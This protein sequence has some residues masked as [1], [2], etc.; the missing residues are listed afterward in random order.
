MGYFYHN[1][2]IYYNIRSFCTDYDLVY[3]SVRYFAR[4]FGT[5]DLFM[6]HLHEN[7]EVIDVLIQRYRRKDK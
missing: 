4:K 3:D 7:R 1:S 2:K 6:K 5:K